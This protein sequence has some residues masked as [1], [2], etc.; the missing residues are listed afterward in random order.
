MLEEDY[1]YKGLTREGCKANWAMDTVRINDFIDVPGMN[2]EQ[3]ARAI[4]KG[5][6]ATAIQA[7]AMVFMQYAGG[8]ITD[9]SCY[10]A[11]EV[12]HAVLVVGYG[13]QNGMQY[14]LVKNSWGDT[15][16]DHGYVKIGFQSGEG[17]CGIQVAPV[18]FELGAKDPVLMVAN[19]Q[20]IS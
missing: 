12:N 17:I 5:P 14:F 11:K 15:W 20:P 16:G 18:Q 19:T 13:E 10:E 2:P 4:M 3:L 1:P 7:D 9:E 8:V 6:V